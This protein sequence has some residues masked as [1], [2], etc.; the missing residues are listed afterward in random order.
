MVDLWINLLKWVV[1]A[2]NV[3]TK[4]PSRDK[5]QEEDIIKSQGHGKR[6]LQVF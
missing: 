2:R 6:L 3:E 1:C 4:M 5:A